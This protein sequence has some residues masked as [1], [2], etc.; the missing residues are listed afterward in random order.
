MLNSWKFKIFI[1]P[2]KEKELARIIRV[3]CKM[4]RTIYD[5]I[6]ICVDRGI[7]CQLVDIPQIDICV[8]CSVSKW[9]AVKTREQNNKRNKSV[10][11]WDESFSFNISCKVYRKESVF[12]RSK[13]ILCEIL[14]VFHNWK[15]MIDDGT[16]L[17]KKKKN[18][19]GS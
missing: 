19:C 12:S 14:A 17:C 9:N 15:F 10:S 8:L 7:Y 6:T 5:S 4:I 13:F 2:S 11:A 18:L 3:V 16:K 1:I